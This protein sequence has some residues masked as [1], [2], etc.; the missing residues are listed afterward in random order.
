[1]AN[2][3]RKRK[4]DLPVIFFFVAT[5]LVATLLI[6]DD[7]ILYFFI[8]SFLEVHPGFAVR[9]A[10]TSLFLF[11]NLG[12]IWFVFKARTQKAQTGMEAMVG[13]SG[14]VTRV[15]GAGLWVQVHGELWRARC[16]ERVNIGDEIVVQ[17]LQGLVLQV[18]VTLPG[19]KA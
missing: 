19:E 12:L 8:E 14:V 2:G 13:K 6:V 1:M 3:K 7:V 9:L 10:V 17:G 15:N 5:V 4:R 18:K 11:I 16:Q